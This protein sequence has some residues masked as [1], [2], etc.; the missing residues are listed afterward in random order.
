[1]LPEHYAKKFIMQSV[2]FPAGVNINTRKTNMLPEH[3]AKKVIMHHNME[4]VDK[5]RYKISDKIRK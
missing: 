1:M 4:F 3:Y 2:F 5:C